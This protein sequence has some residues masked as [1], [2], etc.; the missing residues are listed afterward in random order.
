[1][2]QA[3]LTSYIVLIKYAKI[4]EKA[5]YSIYSVFLAMFLM[6]SISAPDVMTGY[7]LVIWSRSRL[8][9][10]F[11]T[12]LLLGSVL[13]VVA[14]LSVLFMDAAN[15]AELVIGATTV[16]FVEDVV[17]MVG[18]TFERGDGREQ[19]YLASLPSFSLSPSRSRS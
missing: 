2:V 18:G 17:S 11:G 7:S 10:A 9:Q 19:E 1:M 15:N 12:L 6:V 16:L 13:L 8:R 14:S 3:Q 4:N 5:T